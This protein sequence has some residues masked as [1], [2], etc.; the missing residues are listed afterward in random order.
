MIVHAEKAV[1]VRAHRF[2]TGHE[3]TLGIEEELMLLD[4]A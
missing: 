4:V 1:P 2:G 3:Y